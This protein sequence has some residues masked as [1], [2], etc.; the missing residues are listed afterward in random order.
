VVDEEPPLSSSSSAVSSSWAADDY[1]SLL[2]ESMSPIVDNDA[3]FEDIDWV[4]LF[5]A[6]P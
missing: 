2:E 1:S 5:C 3:L 4:A 6:D